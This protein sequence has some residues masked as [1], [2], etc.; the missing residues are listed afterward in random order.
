MVYFA[1][2]IEQSP[3]AAAIPGNRVAPQ[4]LFRTAWIA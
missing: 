4:R 3:A 2:N 1:D